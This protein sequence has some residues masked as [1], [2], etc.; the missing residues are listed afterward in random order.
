MYQS[1][2]EH[3]PSIDITLVI[4]T[5][6]IIMYFQVMPKESW[7]G[8][9]VTLVPLFVGVCDLAGA[10][11]G[12]QYPVCKPGLEFWSTERASCW[13]CTRCAPKFTLSPCAVHQDA[14]CGPLSALELDWSFLSTKKRPENG[15]R[16]LEAVTSKML[17][18]FPDLDQQ[19]QQKQSQEQQH[20]Q[21]L[22]QESRSL[23]DATYDDEIN[24]GD[25]DGF[26][27]QEQKVKNENRNCVYR[28]LKILF[29]N[30]DSFRLV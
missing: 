4:K 1:P 17:W 11:S 23:V 7:C 8:L 18:R 19:Q 5:I 9:L 2:F 22:R 6:V 14:I 27:S 30:F 26:S 10:I 12:S 24:V 15:Q 3:E 25:I 13:P 21:E 28:L 16:R 29:F 20:Q